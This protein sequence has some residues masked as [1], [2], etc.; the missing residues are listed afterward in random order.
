VKQ[1]HGGDHARQFS[2]RSLFLLRF[3]YHNH[4]IGQNLRLQHRQ[5]DRAEGMGEVNH[6]HG[7]NN[8][9]R[10]LKP[11]NIMLDANG[12]FWML[13]SGLATPCFRTF[14]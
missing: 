5:E 7:K 6:T 9:L 10:D 8:T 12:R 2:K 14:K 13:D 3:W 1:A 4:I 11:P